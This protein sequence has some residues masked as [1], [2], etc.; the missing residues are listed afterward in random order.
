MPSLCKKNSCDIGSLKILP[1]FGPHKVIYRFKI[2]KTNDASS[3]RKH[4]FR[5]HY[6]YCCLLFR[7]M[8]LLYIELL[9]HAHTSTIAHTHFSC[10]HLQF[11]R[12][13]GVVF[14]IA[15]AIVFYL[16]FVLFCFR[17]VDAPFVWLNTQRNIPTVRV[18]CVLCVV[19]HCFEKWTRCD[20]Q[21]NENFSLQ[22]VHLVHVNPLPHCLHLCI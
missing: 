19:Y 14:V 4:T 17:Y 5:W 6:C 13:S 15:F 2:T 20:S 11:S 7:H 9:A 18:Y 10:T 12:S 22:F 3:A 21:R 1:I 8:H 16:I